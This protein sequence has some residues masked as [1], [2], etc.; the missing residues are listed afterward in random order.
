MQVGRKEWRT[1]GREET[2]KIESGTTFNDMTLI[3][4]SRKISTLASYLGDPGLKYRSGDRL[5]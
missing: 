4:S 3:S 1:E 2:M 5:S